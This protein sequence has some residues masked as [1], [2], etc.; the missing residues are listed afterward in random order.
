MV[1]TLALDSLTKAGAGAKSGSNT[2]LITSR[3][4]AGQLALEGGTDNKIFRAYHAI[5]I[6]QQYILQRRKGAVITA[7]WHGLPNN[8][9]QHRLLL[10]VCKHVRLLQVPVNILLNHADTQLLSLQQVHHVYI[11]AINSVCTLSNFTWIV[12]LSMSAP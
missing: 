10:H 8:A 3:L 12:E 6:V 1:L 7:Q 9:A 5:C 11:P 2:C 4:P